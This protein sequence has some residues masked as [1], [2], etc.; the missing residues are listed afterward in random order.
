MLTVAFLLLSTFQ[1]PK[2]RFADY[3]EQDALSYQISLVIEP[4]KKQLS[5]EVEYRFR[6]VQAL[7][8]IRLDCVQ[9]RSGGSWQVGF[10]DQAGNELAV[11][12]EG[13]RVVVPLGVKVEAGAEVSFR[14]RLHGTPPDG[15]YF[16]T[17]RYD[18]ALAFTDHYSIRARGWLP[19][20]D[21]PKDRASFRLELAVT[22]GNEVICSGVPVGKQGSDRDGRAIARRQTPSEIPPYMLAVVAGPYA[23]VQEAGDSRL[24]PHFIYQRDVAR[25]KPALVHHAAWLKQ[26]ETAFGPYPYGSYAIVQCPTRWG[27]FEAPGNVQVAENL[28]ESQDHG[29]PTLAHELVHMWFG[30]GVGYAEWR[31]VWLSEGFASYFGPWLHAAAGGPSLQSSLAGMRETWLHSADGRTKSVRWDGFANPDLA[32]NANTYPKGA[33]VLHMLRGELG[34]AAFFKALAAYYRKHVGHSVV[35]AD[36]VAAIEDSSGLELDWFFAQWLD[37]PG[38]PVLKVTPQEG[39]ITVEQT[40]QQGPY[41]CRLRLCWQGAGGKE[42][43]RVLELREQ[44]TVLEL[45]GPVTNLTVDPQVELLFRKAQ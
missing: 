18:E 9:P 13:D 22:A 5:G 44:R 15:F 14:A 35:T 38:C 39:G 28:F 40:Q 2:P 12:W 25:A 3:P 37:R 24:Q 16:K 11:R 23:L 6:A 4:E 34:D 17:N 8:S 1:E 21:N 42:Q 27:G 19:C 43:E 30:D 31:D 20:E 45:P 26:M 32:L 29:V 41:R 36:F 33:W 10:L 7:D